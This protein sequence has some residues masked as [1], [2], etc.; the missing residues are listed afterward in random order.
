[1][2]VLCV[3]KVVGV[4]EDDEIFAGAPRHILKA[5]GGNRRLTPLRPIGAL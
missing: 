4:E 1:M 2:I 3:P 5:P